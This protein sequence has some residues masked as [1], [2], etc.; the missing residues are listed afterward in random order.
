M[1]DDIYNWALGVEGTCIEQFSSE[2][3]GK[4]INRNSLIVTF[5]YLLFIIVPI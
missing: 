3:K 5:I 2:V 4:L 1:N